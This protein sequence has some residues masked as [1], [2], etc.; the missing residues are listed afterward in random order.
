LEPESRGEFVG[1]SSPHLLQTADS[2]QSRCSHSRGV[3]INSKRHSIEWTCAAVGID[4][5]SP[6]LEEITNRLL[7][8]ASVTVGVLEIRLTLAALAIRT[9][10]SKAV[11]KGYQVVSTPAWPRTFPVV[12]GDEGYGIEIVD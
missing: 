11:V 10:Q 4:V 5:A 6:F 9:L 7:S 3:F 8:L 12:F 2:A 1:C